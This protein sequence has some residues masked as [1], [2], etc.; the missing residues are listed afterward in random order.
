MP[1]YSDEDANELEDEVRRIAREMWPKAEF[2]GAAMIESQERDGIFETDE[3]IHIIEVTASRKLEKAVKDSEKL[4]KLLKKK[5]K[6]FPHKHTVGYFITLEEPTA[7]QRTHIT[8]KYGDSIKVLSYDQFRSK[9]IDAK[10]Y[11]Q[12]RSNYAF[13]S[14]RNPKNDGIQ[15]LTYVQLDM[16]DEKGRIVNVGGL[17]DL[18]DS[19]SK[20]VLIGDYGAGKSM[21]LREIF[22]NLRNKYFKARSHKFPVMLNLNEHQG[23]TDTAEALLRHSNRIGFSNPSHL[24]RAW[25]AGYVTLLLDGF[26]EITTIGYVKDFKRLKDIRAASMELL[27]NF[28]KES[29]SEGGVVISGREHYFDSL[30]ELRRALNAENLGL[31]SLN[32][33][34]EVQIAEFLKKIEWSKPVP[35]WLPSRPLLLGY[36]A[37]NGL[38]PEVLAVGDQLEESNAWNNLLSLVCKREAKLEIGV[39]GDTVRHLVE[40]LASLARSKNSGL[41]PLTQLEVKSAFEEVCRQELSERGT[42]LL[43]RLPGLGVTSAEDGSRSFIDH[44][45]AET[46]KAGDVFRFVQEPYASHGHLG[47]LS[48]SLDRLGGSVLGT[49]L[50]ANKISSG[51]QLSSLSRAANEGDGNLATDILQGLLYQEIE[52]SDDI[53]VRD[54]TIPTLTIEPTLNLSHVRFECTCINHLEVPPDLNPNLTP[55]FIDCIVS[56][57]EGRTSQEDLPA[58]MFDSK[59]TIESFAQEADTNAAILSLNLPAPTKVL[60]TVLRK[61][62]LQ[63]GTGRKASALSRGLDQKS[64]EH[65]S[66]VMQLVK[67]EGLAT[68]TTLNRSEVFL[69]AQSQRARVMRILESP[70]ESKD[71]I[72]KLLHY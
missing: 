47:N 3:I 17:S 33:F 36:L 62:Y 65:L 27:R 69:P 29:P 25:R 53:V 18:L 54:A 41:G 22:F 26:D 58:G 19:G 57:V 43:L 32:E 71:P 61:L 64:R 16:T 5:R 72:F 6:E 12:A 68:S 63:R 67:T 31:L 37:A 44:D 15:G 49:L 59:C 30:A 7:D 70:T 13:G 45:F 60:L 46:A 55:K 35:E 20:F 40:R 28:V 1:N 56:L 10:S 48:C 66:K 21:S 9:I 14:A 8:Q 51:Q 52:P 50:S 23:Q 24:I 2:G 34:S 42:Q 39:D 11:L 4:D 38:L